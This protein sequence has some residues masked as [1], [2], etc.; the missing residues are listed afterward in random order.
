MI[1]NVLLSSVRPN[2]FQ[3]RQGEDPLHI[4]NLAKSIE[5]QGML[6]IPS[7]RKLDDG[8][9]ELVFGHSRF[10]AYKILNETS[11]GDY[12]LMPLNIVE[13]DD[14]GMFEQAVAENLERKDLSP[15]EEAQAMLVYR[16]HFK[17]TS[18]E[19][20]ELFH[21]NESAVRNK[22]RLLGLPEDIQDCI[23]KGRMTEGNA[24]EMLV[25]LSMPKFSQDRWPEIPER[26]KNGTDIHESVSR[27]VASSGKELDKKGWK[28]TD[29]LQGEGIVGICK[30]CEYLMK[31]DNRDFCMQ[32]EC[33]AAK[34]IAWKQQYLEQA[35]LMSGLPVLDEKKEYSD[36]YSSFDWGNEAALSEIRKNGCEN[37]RVM[38]EEYHRDNKITHLTEEGFPKARIVCCKKGSQCTC[39]KAIQSG[40]KLEDMGDLTQ[41]IQQVKEI[42]RQKK[43]QIRINK[44]VC[45]DLINQAASSILTG[46][47]EENQSIWQKIYLSLAGYSSENAADRKA[48]EGGNVSLRDIKY[49]IAKNLANHFIWRYE[50][51]NEVLEQVN[52]NLTEFGLDPLPISFEGEE[53]EEEKPEEEGRGAPRPYGEE[54][55][56]GKSLME[57]FEG[58]AEEEGEVNHANSD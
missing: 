31:R 4:E 1:E 56:A 42:E 27:M 53:E 52:K 2:P 51:P 14:Q 28:H 37:L 35:S 24:R 34:E 44:Q 19:I 43:E 29:E 46:I 40:V 17:K 15:I 7:A 49:L 6:Q 13:L 39:L 38:F 48:V 10:A 47:E 12:S 5:E 21:L 32:P 25:F 11:D 55:P 36:E 45:M 8:T 30:G 22:L 20:G 50:N 58:E 33:Y 54:K 16:D 9:Y 18:K 57:V 41:T 23:T 3:T 26:A